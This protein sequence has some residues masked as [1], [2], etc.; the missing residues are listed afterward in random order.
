MTDYTHVIP[1]PRVIVQVFHHM[2][3]YVRVCCMHGLAQGLRHCQALSAERQIV[4][5]YLCVD[6]YVCKY[7]S[8]NV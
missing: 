6:V 5:V 1:V 8:M 2:C 7:T 3:T 4:H